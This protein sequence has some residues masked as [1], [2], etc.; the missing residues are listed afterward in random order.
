MEGVNVMGGRI[1]CGRGEDL[2]YRLLWP[3]DLSFGDGA[4]RTTIG[5]EK[6]QFLADRRTGNIYIHV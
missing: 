3:R 6:P 5:A 1:P 4:E 2:I